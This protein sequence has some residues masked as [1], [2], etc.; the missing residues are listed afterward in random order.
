MGRACVAAPIRDRERGGDRR[1]QRLRPAARSST[2]RRASASWRRP[3]WTPRCASPSGWASSWRPG[4]RARRAAVRSRRLAGAPAPA[5][6]AGE[7]ERRADGGVGP[8][9]AV[10]AFPI[11]GRLVRCAA[12][13]ARV[14]AIP[15][16]RAGRRG[17]ARRGAGAGAEAAAAG[18]GLLRLAR[19]AVRQAD[20]RGRDRRL[21]RDAGLGGARGG[22]RGGA[23]AARAAADRA[24]PHGHRGLWADLYGAMRDRGHRTGFYIDA[25]AGVDSALWDLRGK[26]A[27]LPVYALLGGPCGPAAG[28]RRAGVLRGGRAHA[29]DAVVGRGD[30]APWRGLQRAQA[31]LHRGRGRRRRSRPARCAGRWARR[32]SC[33]WT[34]TTRCAW[35]RRWGW[36]APW[37]GSG[38]RF[39]EAPID[40]ED[41]AGLRAPGRRRCDLPIAYGEGERTRWQFRDR[42]VAGAGGRRAAGRGL[43][44]HLGAAAHRPAGR[45]V[46]RGLRAAPVRR[47]GGVHRRPPCTLRRRCPTCTA[48][49]TARG[50]FARGNALLAR[51]LELRDG[52]YVL[53][54][55]PGLGVEAGTRRRSQRAT[56]IR[57]RP[58]D[59]G[60]TA[61]HQGTGHEPSES[62][63]RGRAR[64][65]AD[66]QAEVVR[67]GASRSRRRS[68]TPWASASRCRVRTVIR[69]HTDEGLVGLGEC[70]PQPAGP[71]HRPG[72][73]AGGDGARWCVGADP[74]DLGAVL[75]GI[76]RR[77]RGGRGG[78]RLL[79]PDGQAAGLPVSRLLGA[80][81]P[82][83]AV[84]HSCYVFFRAP[85]PGGARA[86]SR[87]RTTSRT[88][89]A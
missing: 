64:R 3:R 61:G 25:L 47:A 46:P 37:S 31:A 85:E 56:G 38:F 34:C 86:P 74:L 23:H 17:G 40:P 55:G 26:R 72:R 1:P 36:G 89:R 44:R 82:L 51:P 41:D 2:S 30:S 57:G 80:P 10:E 21:G 4:R 58:L 66:H 42:L 29:R 87:P 60:G 78:D 28:G 54:D 32:W 77:H 33:A 18:A 35:T 24:R 83:A 7:G 50:S 81:R 49:S 59:T 9:R 75:A 15:G 88:G 12:D 48:W 6:R 39:L 19:G 52:A 43:H 76:G 63:Q 53:P 8:L 68:C 5:R 20:H 22:G 70:G 11:A 67:R 16:S 13:R 45:G 62:D 27:G 14:E 65:D 84:P 69:L 73:H 71:L 79:G